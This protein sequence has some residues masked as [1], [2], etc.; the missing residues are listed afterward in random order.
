MTV[1]FL[2]KRPWLREGSQV[3]CCPSC[4][5][6]RLHRRAFLGG[7]VLGGAM[8]AFTLPAQAAA[9]DAVAKL[10]PRGNFVIRN[11]YV[12]TMEP[13]QSDLPNADVHVQNGQIAD[14]G[15]SLAAQ[16][17]QAIDGKGFIVLPG[18]VDTHWHMWTTLLRNMAG[19]DKS[20]GYFAS[21]GALSKFCTPQDMYYGAL[22]AVAEALYAGITTAHDWCHN[23]MSPQH[24]EENIRALQESG[25]RARFSYGPAR[26]KWLQVI[27]LPD[28]ERLNRSWSKYAN[29][30]LLS[31]GLAWRGVQA[32]V[33][34]AQGKLETRQLSPDFYRAEYDAA[35]QMG[36]PISAHVN[37]GWNGTSAWDRGHIAALDKLGL[38]Y[39]GLQVIHA[40][41]STPQEMDAL[42]AAGA[43]VTVSPLSE[44]RIGY[45]IPKIKEF[46][47]HKVNLGLSIDTPT[48]TGSASMFEVMKVVQNIE[49][50]RGENEFNLPARRVLELATIEGARSL[51]LDARI[52]SLAKGKRA[53]LIMI[54]AHDINIGPF[55]DAA[56]ML[57]DSAQPSN[58]DTVI[59]DGR[60]L[61]Q[62]GKLTS[63]NV[64][65]LM[66][67][68]S[69]ANRALRDRAK[70]T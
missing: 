46:L 19:G 30:G 50:G 51:G 44:M 41:T 7:L 65:Q 43:K 33:P 59:V 36:I 47:D 42:A 5:A 3:S 48:L 17:A 27:D 21:T 13:A 54:N 10:S 22:L 63:I 28:L 66:R 23:V 39:D 40:L 29:E 64:E 24:A 69:A 1:Q 34:N 62:N 20:H 57:V 9:S 16:G 32:P 70:W 2:P 6:G 8:S 56:T 35:R 49:N 60:I 18:L 67:E 12:M 4:F 55:A 38:L 15:T 14:V 45:G 31:L 53:D 58:V 26:S 68:A 61:K 11:A 52:G 25:I 37:Q